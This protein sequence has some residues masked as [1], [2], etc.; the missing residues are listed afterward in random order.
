M[1]EADRP[2]GY[3]MGPQ[4][5]LWGSVLWQ[6]AVQWIAGFSGA[7]FIHTSEFLVACG[8]F[9]EVCGDLIHHN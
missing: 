9:V 5:A 3:M 7:A 2:Q 6:S 4:G 8:V 1:E